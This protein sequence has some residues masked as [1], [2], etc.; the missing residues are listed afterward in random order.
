MSALDN[1]LLDKSRILSL[2]ERGS[3]ILRILFQ[4]VK[5]FL[6]PETLCH[7]WSS[8]TLHSTNIPILIMVFILCLAFVYQNCYIGR[9]HTC[10]KQWM[11]RI[12]DGKLMEK[13]FLI[14]W[15]A[16]TYFP[17]S[18]I[19]PVGF[20]CAERC[21]YNLL[22]I[23]AWLLSNG[24][25]KLELSCDLRSNIKPFMKI[26]KHLCIGILMIKS[27]SRSFDW[28]DDFSLSLKASQ[29]GSIKSRVNLAS[30]LP[31]KQF[32]KQLKMNNEFERL[33]VG[34]RLIESV[35]YRNAKVGLHFVGDWKSNL[36]LKTTKDR[37]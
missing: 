27:W 2:G 35:K 8:G 29:V 15:A 3:F 24:I 28:R 26:I 31:D 6:L 13:E 34:I 21:L 20:I 32:D 12:W 10:I 1:P 14:I 22:P 37:I 17:I 23:Y 7:D 5:S 9:Q 36:N 25:R 30:L 18:N 33:K 4:N 11:G 16:M 19:I